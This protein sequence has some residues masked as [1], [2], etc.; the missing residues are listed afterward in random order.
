MIKMLPCVLDECY[1]CKKMDRVMAHPF[2]TSL[3]TICTDKKL[4][5]NAVL[6]PEGQQCFQYDPI[7]VDPNAGYS[8]LVYPLDKPTILPTVWALYA[9]GY[10][11]ERIEDIFQTR[12][13]A[14]RY[15]GEEGDEDYNEY[16]IVQVI[17]KV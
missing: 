6:P 8:Q 4:L 14:E 12:E 3:T 11:D 1:N 16:R 13:A 15:V 2:A 7:P 5:E 17:I 9:G 10:Y